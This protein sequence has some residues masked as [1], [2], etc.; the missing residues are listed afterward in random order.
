MIFYSIL[1][2]CISSYN[3]YALTV[4]LL[5]WQNHLHLTRSHNAKCPQSNSNILWFIK[6]NYLFSIMLTVVCMSTNGIK[7]YGLSYKVHIALTDS[8]SSTSNKL[9]WN[10]MFNYYIY[11]A[12]VVSF[13]VPPVRVPDF[14]LEFIYYW[15]SFDS[16]PCEN[17]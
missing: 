6:L 4:Y 3:H 16:L 13:F 9:K 14:D 17:I 11:P 8:L 7:L 5:T 15:Y 1:L 2:Y 12:L 10:L